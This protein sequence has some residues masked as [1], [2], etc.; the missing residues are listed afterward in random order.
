MIQRPEVLLLDTL[1]EDHLRPAHF[2]WGH[3][4]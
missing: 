4:I 1:K 3:V 2:Q